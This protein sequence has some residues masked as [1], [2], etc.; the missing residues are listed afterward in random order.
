MH[1]NAKQYKVIQWK[2]KHDKANPLQSK[3]SKRYT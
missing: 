3:A 1:S 2:A